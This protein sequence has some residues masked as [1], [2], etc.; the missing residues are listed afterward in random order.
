MK[1]WQRWQKKVEKPEPFIPTVYVLVGD[2]GSGKTVWRKAQQ[3]A[4]A[5][6]FIVVQS[7]TIGR[8]LAG[9]LMAIQYDK[10]LIIDPPGRLTNCAIDDLQHGLAGY[11]HLEVM[12]FPRIATAS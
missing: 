7:F 1:L 8:V 12:Q 10:D 4:Y 3:Q 2:T 11:C 9:V 5:Q 6:R